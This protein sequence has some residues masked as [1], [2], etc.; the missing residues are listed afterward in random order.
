[1]D[2]DDYLKALQEYYSLIALDMPA[3]LMD[4]GLRVLRIISAPVTMPDGA[5]PCR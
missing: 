3:S 1:M 5:R 4:G 2:G